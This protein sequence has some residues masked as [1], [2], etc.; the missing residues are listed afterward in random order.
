MADRIAESS[1]AITKYPT[2]VPVIVE[3]TKSSHAP[4]LE[5]FKFLVDREVTLGQFMF[6]VRKRME[7]PAERGLF[8][9]INGSMCPS[10]FTMGYIYFTKRDED[11]FLY[12]T[13]SSENVFGN[14]TMDLCRRS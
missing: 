11:G 13:Y 12:I 5:R 14:M 9:H 10:T 3:K 8:F 4:V 7:L 1:G 6:V 2:K